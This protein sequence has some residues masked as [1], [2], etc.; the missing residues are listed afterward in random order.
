MVAHY[1]T[2][3]W[4]LCC[5]ASPAS[6]HSLPHAGLTGARRRGEVVGLL[7]SHL[8]RRGTGP[9]PCRALS[10]SR[11]ANP[12]RPPGE[13]LR[14]TALDKNTHST[15]ATTLKKKKKGCFGCVSHHYCRIQYLVFTKTCSCFQHT[16]F[17]PAL[18]P[19]P[20]MWEADATSQECKHGRCR[21][22]NDVY[23]ACLFQFICL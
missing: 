8:A 12:N 9:S 1:Q 2:A 4:G 15:L 7:W 16:P 17:R 3:V 5:A 22:T 23:C 6:P 20:F 11:Q 14:G 19:R 18:V 21:T 10:R 13:E